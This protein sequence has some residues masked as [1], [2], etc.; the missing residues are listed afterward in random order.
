LQPWDPQTK[1]TN[2]RP[3]IRLQVLFFLGFLLESLGLD[4]GITRILLTF[5][6]Q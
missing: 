1:V 6:L 3:L 2:T 5:M 4:V